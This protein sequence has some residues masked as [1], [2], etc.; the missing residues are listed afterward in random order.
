[1]RCCNNSRITIF[2]QFY[3]V[4]SIDITDSLSVSPKKTSCRLRID[5]YGIKKN[6]YSGTVQSEVVLDDLFVEWLEKEDGNEYVPKLQ[7]LVMFNWVAQWDIATSHNIQDKMSRSRKRTPVSCNVCYKSQKKSKRAC[8]RLFR[9]R[10][11]QLIF[12]EDYER[13]PYLPI[14]VMDPWNLGGDGKSYFHASPQDEF[15]IKL[16]RK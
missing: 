3:T 8:N 5:T 12:M 10:T 7:S 15:F 13:L 11:R 9:R 6:M 1:M 16:M 4:N 14:E 2:Y